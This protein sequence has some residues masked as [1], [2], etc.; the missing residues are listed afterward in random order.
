[1]YQVIPYKRTKSHIYVLG[2]DYPF[3]VE[4]GNISSERLYCKRFVLFFVY[5]IIGQGV[6]SYAKE[7]AILHINGF[8][9]ESETQYTFYIFTRKKVLWDECLSEF[10]YCIIE[11]CTMLLIK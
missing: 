4:I 1:M 10:S 9:Y 3:P 8:D 2:Y 11:K 7:R 5:Y 6:Q